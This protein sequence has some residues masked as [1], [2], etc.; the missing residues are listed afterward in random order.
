ME[1]ESN[2]TI[3]R[4]FDGLLYPFT[5]IN[6]N[7]PSF[8]K[9]TSIFALLYTFFI[10]ILGRSIACSTLSDISSHIYCS[11]SL[12]HAIISIILFF[13][14]VSLYLNRLTMLKKNTSIKE[15]ITQINIKSDLKMLAFVL[16]TIIN[17][18]LL[19]GSIYLL[20]TRKATPNFYFELGYF[21]LFSSLIII[22]TI[23]L[24]T[25]TLSYR[26]MTGKPLLK[27]S[28]IFWPI[29]DNIYKY[30]LWFLFSFLFFSWILKT[31]SG[32]V[33]SIPTTATLIPFIIGE[34]L[35]SFTTLTIFAYWILQIQYQ[36]KCFFKDI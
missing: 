26:Y 19:F 1:K 30:L 28:N 20:S 25:T 32:Y 3:I 11:N 33:L 4:F 10:F 23:Y 16:I 17:I 29:V 34:F 13:I 8:M 2:K 6:N 9:L 7:L 31:I 24:L 5:F 35:L 36:E 18:I 12:I 15:L 21:I 27:L 14:L 22:N